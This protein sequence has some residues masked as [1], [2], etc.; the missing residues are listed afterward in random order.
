[1]PAP[2]GKTP[3]KKM[4]NIQV[5]GM[6]D[7]SATRNTL[8]FF[9]ERRIV[10]H[11]VDLRKKP[12][13]RGELQRFVERLGCGGAPRRHL[14]VV[15][16]AGSR[17]PVDG[18]AGTVT[19]LL[20]EP[21]AVEA[22][23]RP[24]RRAGHRRQGRGDLEGLA[25]EAALAGRW[26]GSVTRPMNRMAPVSASRMRNMNGWSEAQCL[27][28]RAASGRS[29]PPRV[30]ADG[31]R[32]GGLGAAFVDV[33]VRLMDDGGDGRRS[34]AV[35]PLRSA[36]RRVHGGRHPIACSV[37]EVGARVDPELRHEQAQ[38]VRV[39]GQPSGNAATSSSRHCSRLVDAS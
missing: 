6:D 21:A 20:A 22:A 16:R 25:R 8:R 3:T 15:P 28:S 12:I 7:S 39:P 1:M 2:L 14:Q 19:R 18:H 31:R 30:P 33:D 32:R 26:L 4:P 36:R 9:R 38:V 35:I 10:V 23:A 34:A 24:L 17:L 29:H 37:L 5:F 27:V 11:Y 13:A